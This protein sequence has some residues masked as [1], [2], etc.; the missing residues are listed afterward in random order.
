MHPEAKLALVAERL[1]QMYGTW[2]LHDGPVLRGPGAVTVTVG[3][4]HT[5]SPNHLDLDMILNTGDP[6]PITVLDC[7]TGVAGNPEHAIRQAVAMWSET[8][9]ATVLELL[10]RRGDFGDHYRG[11]DPGGFPGWHM[12]TGG[13]TGL[14]HK[15]NPTLLQQWMVESTPWTTLAPV[16]TAGLDRPQLNGIKF[17][18]AAVG[19][20]ET[21][22][23]R[24]NGEIHEPSSAAL[25]AL[26]WPRPNEFASAR[27]FI[28]LVHPE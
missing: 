24:I 8:T 12:I 15:D 19:D 4:D 16:L 11:A 3:E 14:G 22:E 7:S 1:N 26:D 25:L 28:L 2:T 6:N 5:G 27:T 23:V 9:A 20:F 10:T 13:I 18:I 21:A 17:F